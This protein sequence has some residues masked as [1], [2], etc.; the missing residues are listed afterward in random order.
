MPNVQLIKDAANTAI[1]EMVAAN[2]SMVQALNDMKDQITPW[3]LRS[4]VPPPP[5]GSTSRTTSTPP[6]PT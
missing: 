1:E 2:T 5:R 3:P 6:R 4:P